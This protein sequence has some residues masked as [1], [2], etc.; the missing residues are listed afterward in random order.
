LL[1]V[2]YSPEQFSFPFPGGLFEIGIPQSADADWRF[3]PLPRGGGSLGVSSRL[4]SPTLHGLRSLSR[5]ATGGGPPP[6]STEDLCVIWSLTLPSSTR[7]AILPSLFLFSVLASCHRVSCFLPLPLC[8]WRREGFSFRSR[9]SDYER[10]IQSLL[11]L[12]LWRLGGLF[13]TFSPRRPWTTR[14]SSFRRF[15]SALAMGPI[16]V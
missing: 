12:F 3:A 14:L 5:W 9:M 6:S 1:L 16:M 8:F 11:P 2:G 4:H 15:R 10:S 7:R 13:V